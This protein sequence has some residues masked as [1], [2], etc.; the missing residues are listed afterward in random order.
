MNWMITTIGSVA[1][2]E[3]IRALGRRS[4]VM[5]D[6]GILVPVHRL[7]EMLAIGI[8]R[9]V[10]SPDARRGVP[11]LIGMLIRDMPAAKK[12]GEVEVRTAGPR[13]DVAEVRT[14]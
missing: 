12:D 14:I 6:V 1:A 7:P 10:L 8:G 4:V 5:R 2:E 13:E 3:A 9:E 11:W